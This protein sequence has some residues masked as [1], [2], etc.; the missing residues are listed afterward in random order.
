MRLLVTWIITTLILRS[1][2]LGPVVALV[3]QLMARLMIAEMVLPE[4]E[5]WSRRGGIMPL[6]EGGRT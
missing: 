5:A 2:L 6:Y 4:K 3:Q 1:L